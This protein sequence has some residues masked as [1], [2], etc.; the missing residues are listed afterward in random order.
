MENKYPL[1]MELIEKYKK[2]ELNLP[3]SAPLVYH[4]N[5]E[6]EKLGD[7][8]LIF[9]TYDEFK[10]LVS[11]NDELRKKRTRTFMG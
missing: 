9:T 2:G 3:E 7:K 8:F 4:L 5:K 11:L 1:L 6:R 10:K